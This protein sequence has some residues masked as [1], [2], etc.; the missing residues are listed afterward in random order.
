[1]KKFKVGV[2][3]NFDTEHTIANGQ[4]VKTINLWDKL[5]DVYGKENVVTFNTYGFKK[6][7]IVSVCRF[8]EFMKQCE[9]VVMLPAVSAVKILVPIGVKFKK[10]YSCKIHYVVIGA[11]LG[12][13][14]RNKKSLLNCVKK[15]DGVFVETNTL[16]NELVELGIEK[17]YLF[18][19]FKQMEIL[20][21]DELVYQWELPLK[22]CFFARVTEQKGIAELVETVK[23]INGSKVVY[24]LDIYGPVDEEYKDTF[25]R[26]KEAFG[27][28][29][30]YLGVIESNKARDVVKNY[31]LQV[32]PTKFRTEGIPGSIIDSYCAGVPVA[33]SEWNSCHDIV[34]EGV[35]GI[36]FEFGDFDELKKLLE[37]IAEN[38]DNINKMKK[39]C[40]LKARE[41]DA[42]NA[43]K[44]LTKRME[45][46]V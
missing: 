1:M 8:L 42:D 26:L 29:I 34:D 36:S 35:T 21:E 7:P 5:C 33:A 16:K 28:N 11:W 15:L 40:L 2:C 20:K 39:N 18:P 30:K 22:L 37:K 23:A 44:I 46:E 24:H 31:F 41:Y 3:G 19:N 4:T 14:L 25:E 9:N 32:F 27:E 10:K 45:E 17:T 43:I 38:P 12:K 13:L 6:N